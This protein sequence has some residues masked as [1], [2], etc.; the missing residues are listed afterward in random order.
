MN[1]HLAPRLRRKAGSQNRG[2][3]GEQHGWKRKGKRKRKKN[4]GR[5]DKKKRNWFSAIPL[6]DRTTD[7]S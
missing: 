5:R 7:N 6:P 1:E 4:G 2:A 3:S